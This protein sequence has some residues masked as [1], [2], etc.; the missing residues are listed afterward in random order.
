MISLT[1][2]GDRENSLLG[3]R[4]KLCQGACFMLVSKIIVPEMIVSK[5]WQLKTPAQAS[6]ERGIREY[7]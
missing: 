3:A 1:I 2:M 4:S 6:L 5:R 7:R